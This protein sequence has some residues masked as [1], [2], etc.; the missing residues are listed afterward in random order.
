[1]ERRH[2][3][4]LLVKLTL[5]EHHIGVDQ[6]TCQKNNL[7]LRFNVALIHL[8]EFSKFNFSIFDNTYSQENIIPMVI[9]IYPT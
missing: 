8:K 5:V 6:F 7:R 2:R 9:F 4:I 1:M 3:F